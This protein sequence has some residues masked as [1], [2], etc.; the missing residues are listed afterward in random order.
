MIKAGKGIQP[1]I[2]IALDALPA[3]HTITP[4]GWINATANPN[5]DNVSLWLHDDGP[6]SQNWSAGQSDEISYWLL[7][8]DNPPEP[9]ADLGLRSGST[10]LDFESSH[11]CFSV[12]DATQSTSGTVQPIAGYT[13]TAL[14]LTY[15]LGSTNGNWVQLRCNFDPPAG[16]VGL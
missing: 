3:D 7:A 13:D 10:W 1:N 9:W 5:D 12:K 6:A 8:Q 2:R 4:Q 11:N 15:D 16:F 14:Q